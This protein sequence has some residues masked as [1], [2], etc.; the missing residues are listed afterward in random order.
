MANPAEMHND[1]KGFPLETPI[2]D[3]QW[4]LYYAAETYLYTKLVFLEVNNLM[5]RAAVRAIWDLLPKMAT[6]DQMEEAVC[7]GLQNR[8]DS[9]GDQ[10]DD[11]IWQQFG[12][13]AP[14]L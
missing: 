2:T 7:L 11:L 8:M 12:A 3:T 4:R 5:S 6:D 10:G 13:V 1:Y 14:W 9:A